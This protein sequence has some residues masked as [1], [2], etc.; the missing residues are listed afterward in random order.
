MSLGVCRNIGINKVVFVF[1]FVREVIFGIILTFLS[2]SEQKLFGPFSSSF[3]VV[4]L[5]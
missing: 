5:M 3:S 1:L 4:S 2:L